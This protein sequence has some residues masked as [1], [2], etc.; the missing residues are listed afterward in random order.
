MINASGPGICGAAAMVAVASMLSGHATWT[1]A[2]RCATN[3]RTL[4]MDESSD[5]HAARAILHLAPL[6]RRQRLS[7][8][9]RSADQ[10]ERT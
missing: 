7:E 3:D 4:A 9:G 1:A 5:S 10:G 8:P 6:T 2:T